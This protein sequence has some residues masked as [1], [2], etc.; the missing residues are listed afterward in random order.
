MIE[1]FL[2]SITKQKKEISEKT[3]P[4]TLGHH[5]ATMVPNFF[6]S[7]CLG[8]YQYAL[9]TLDTSLLKHTIIDS[10]NY[11]ERCIIHIIQEDE[12]IR[13]RFRAG[14]ITSLKQINV[15]SENS[16]AFILINQRITHHCM[17]QTMTKQSNIHICGFLMTK[18]RNSNVHYTQAIESRSQRLEKEKQ[19]TY[20]WFRAPYSENLSA[21]YHDLTPKKI[22]MKSLLYNQIMHCW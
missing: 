7:K 14:D 22:V 19:T 2:V 15:P 13:M 6:D 10:R 17:T 16:T 3:L 8:K 1:Y 12:V 20:D 11:N 9:G 4:E 18:L 21:G 5:E